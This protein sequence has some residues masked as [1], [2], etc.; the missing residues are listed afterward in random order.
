MSITHKRTETAVPATP[1]V[2]PETLIAEGDGVITRF[3]DPEWNVSPL[4]GATSIPSGNKVVRFDFDVTPGQRGSAVAGQSLI[5]VAKELAFARLLVPPAGMRR[6][7]AST[8][9]IDVSNLSLFSRWLLRRGI[10]HFSDVTQK[11]VDEFREHLMINRDWETGD[12]RGK[13]QTLQ[14]VLILRTLQRLW[15]YKEVL[16]VPLSFY[17]WQGVNPRVV[18]GFQKLRGEENKTP[19]IPDDI[20]AV[21]GKHAIRYIDVFSKDIINLRVRLEDMRCQRLALGF[22]RKR[23]QSE[24]D[25]HIFRRFTKNLVLTIDPDTGH[26]WRKVWSAYSEFR[27]EERMLIAAC[28]IVVAWL[29]GMRVSEILAIRDAPVVSEKTSDG[30][31]HLKVKSTLFKGIPEPQGR[32]ET[33]VIVPPVANA[34]KTIAAGTVWYRS[35]PG[36]VLFRNSMGQPLRTGVINKYINQFR[37]HVTT[38]FPS[39]P[40]PAGED[41]AQWL[42]HTRQFRRTLARHIARQPFGVIAGMLQYKHVHVAT[43]EG[44]A[45]SENLSTWRSLLKQELLLANA[46]FLDEV[47]HDV[48]DGCVTGPKGEQMLQTF[49]GSAGDRRDDD[50]A[51]YLRHK[52]KHFYPGL[53]NY[54]FF[55]PETAMCLTGEKTGA[56]TSPVMSYCHP[57]R[58]ANSCISARH[59]PAWE[60]A[61]ADAEAMRRVPKLS[62]L[63]RVA[64]DQEIERM[65]KAII[66]LKE[67]HHGT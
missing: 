11:M 49:R 67:V 38:L 32:K 36:D 24:I 61:V 59:K 64:L 6:K 39:S 25:W 27:H 43:F 40:V 23:V 8:V 9:I 2:R 62:P 55:E 7:S 56:Q 65:R 34:L 57:D 30:Q 54:C 1:F 19:V 44:Y 16:S 14:I 10:R 52:A 3:S 18:T 46:D 35:S 45:G 63:Q 13:R 42:F 51:Y 31:S 15:E 12:R 50:I 58:C 60:N 26:P 33:W 37:D 22:S 53:L 17:P 66:H 41:G 4:I 48:V 20:L 5:Q 21:M 29:S 47:A 28:Y